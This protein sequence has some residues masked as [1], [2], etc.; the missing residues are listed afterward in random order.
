MKEQKEKEGCSGEGEENKSGERRGLLFCTN[1]KQGRG[2]KE[3]ANL[4]PLM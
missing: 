1:A 2:E 3:H 4:S